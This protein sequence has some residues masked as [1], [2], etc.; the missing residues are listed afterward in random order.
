MAPLDLVAAAQKLAPELRSRTAEVETARRIPADL[1]AR[2]GEAG[3][4]R[5]FV[6]RSLGGEELHPGLANAGVEEL[7]RSDASVAWVAF[8][9]MTSGSA[10]A[11]IPEATAREVFAHPDTLVTGVFAPMGR[12]EREADGYR[13]TGRWSFASGSDNADWIL[14]GCRM[15]RDGE[16]ERGAGGAQRAHMLLFP[17]DAVD[18]LGNWDGTGL[19]G[20]GSGEFE[21]N[22]ALVPESRIVGFSQDAP[23]PRPLYQFPRFGLLALG[24]AAVALGTAR[25]AID[26]LVE[27]ARGKTPTGSRR[28]LAERPAAQADVAKA[29]A[30]LGSAR[31]YLYDAIDRCYARAE[32]GDPL[33]QDLRRD[34][35]LAT[36]HAVGSA[37][38]TVDRMYHLGG[39][40]SVHRE[41]PL[42]R[43]FRDIHVVTQHLM[44]A[45]PVLEVIGKTFLAVDVDT[46]QL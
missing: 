36:T 7:A 16:P 19:C 41:H 9:G 2:L 39:G 29:E 15:F 1:S 5:A 14:G 11:G 10:L 33:P 35:R 32:S 43:R 42:G 18:V 27:L 22:G 26:D 37:S 44:V 40:S 24:I 31:L 25:A 20:S 3:F 30:V 21:V 38:K 12:A 23:I 8:I 13:A 46:G 6:P 4:Y 17:R 34:L 45:P 28:P